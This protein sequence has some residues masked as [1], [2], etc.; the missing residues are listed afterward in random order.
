MPLNSHGTLTLGVLLTVY[1]SNLRLFVV[2]LAGVP[3]T[4]TRTHAYTQ[5][6][7]LVI[8]LP[9]HPSQTLKPSTSLHLS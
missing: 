3:C 7:L 1:V 2:L 8:L 9:S 5:L 6:Q 4:H